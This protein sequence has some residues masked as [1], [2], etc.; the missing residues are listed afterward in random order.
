MTG[1]S[2]DRGK[3]RPREITLAVVLLCVAVVPLALTITHFYDATFAGLYL[4]LHLWFAA[5]SGRGRQGSRIGVTITTVVG[6]LFVAPLVVSALSGAFSPADQ[7]FA[8]FGLLGVC[9]GAAGVILLYL[10][11]GNAH[12]VK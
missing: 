3:T 2:D 5:R 1:I 6:L 8:L 9:V 4:L 10:R 11:N 12:F 7:Q